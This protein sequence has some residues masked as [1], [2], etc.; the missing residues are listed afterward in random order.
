MSMMISSITNLKFLRMTAT[1]ERL[2]RRHLEELKRKL[3]RKIMESMAIVAEMV[4]SLEL[5]RKN[6]SAQR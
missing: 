6:H 3:K 5:L 1:L 4:Q 2:E